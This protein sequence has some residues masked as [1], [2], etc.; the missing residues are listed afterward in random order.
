MFRSSS[1]DE[2]NGPLVLLRAYDWLI[3]DRS[4][5][6]DTR[7]DAANLLWRLIA[8]TQEKS[9]EELGISTVSNVFHGVGGDS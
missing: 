7:I 9:N 4:I 3:S 8:K 2:Y 5:D 6:L 1:V